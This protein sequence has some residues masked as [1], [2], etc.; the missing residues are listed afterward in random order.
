MERPKTSAEVRRE[1]FNRQGVIA[2]ELAELALREIDEALVDCPVVRIFPDL[3]P[4][5]EPPDTAA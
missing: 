2:R 1:K 5:P 4:Q 3:L